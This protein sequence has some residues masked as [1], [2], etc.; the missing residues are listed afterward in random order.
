MTGYHFNLDASPPPIDRNGA[1]L[2]LTITGLSIPLYRDFSAGPFN[3]ELVLTGQPIVAP[4][5]E[6][7][8]IGV[9]ADLVQGEKRCA[10]PI[11]A[12]PVVRAVDEGYNGV[13]GNL[14]DM[15]NVVVREMRHLIYAAADAMLLDGNVLGWGIYDQKKLQ[16]N[17][18]PTVFDPTRI[19][20]GQ[21]VERA[22]PPR[23][24][25]LDGM[26]GG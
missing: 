14:I 7:W 6:P 18:M 13:A 19:L 11:W 1:A 24:D 8:K 9:S 3:L 21:N 5:Y 20:V 17:V 25:Q 10:V 16:P 26:L 4:D 23:N 12:S 2:K 15:A 22:G